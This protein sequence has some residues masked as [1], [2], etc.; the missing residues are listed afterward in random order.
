MADGGYGGAILPPISQ[1]ITRPTNLVGK[2]LAYFSHGATTVNAKLTVRAQSR[3]RS[4]QPL[5]GCVVGE[6]LVAERVHNRQA[7]KW[8]HK[9][10]NPRG[11]PRS[12]KT[13]SQEAPHGSEVGSKNAL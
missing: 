9:V 2:R 12:K 13:R 7:G 8:W 10:G 11:A 5:P 1:Y 3:A 6:I 4:H